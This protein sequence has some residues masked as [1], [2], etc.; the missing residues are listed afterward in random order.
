M[1]IKQ[2]VCYLLYYAIGFY[3]PKSNARISL[4]SRKIR[5]ILVKSFAEGPFGKNINIQRKATI[6]RR[7]SIGDY[8]G[9]GMNC[10]VQGG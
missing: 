3:L 5:E 10:V 4:C 6:A 7:I 9:I 8:S 1:R 2:Y